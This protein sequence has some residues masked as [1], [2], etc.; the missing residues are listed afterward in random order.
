MVTALRW[1]KEGTG[2]SEWN[3]S[4]IQSPALWQLAMCSGLGRAHFWSV[5]LGNWYSQQWL[6]AYRSDHFLLEKARPVSHEPLWGLLDNMEK[7]TAVLC[8]HQAGNRATSFTCAQKAGSLPGLWGRTGVFLQ[9]RDTLTYIHIYC[10][11]QRKVVPTFCTTGWTYAYHIVLHR[12]QSINI[13]FR[14]LYTSTVLV[15]WQMSSQR[16]NGG[17]WD[18]HTNTAA[19]YQDSS[20]W[21]QLSDLKDEIL[22]KM[23]SCFGCKFLKFI[24]LT[25]NDEIWRTSSNCICTFQH[26]AHKSVSPYGAHW[27]M[28]WLIKILCHFC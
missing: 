10:K 5:L 19:S 1:Q 11:F 27:T 8:V 17:R 2:S 12:S 18:L 6:L 16:A 20:R 14:C 25:E 28:I 3:Q 24:F 23:W 26:C 21:S 4:V 22:W 7:H 13:L 9:C 15:T